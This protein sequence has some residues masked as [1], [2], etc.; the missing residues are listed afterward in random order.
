MFFVAERCDSGGSNSDSNKKDEANG[1]I[2]G[3][4]LG[5]IFGILLIAGGIATWMYLK[6]RK[7]E[8]R[9]YLINEPEGPSRED[10]VVPLRSKELLSISEQDEDAGE[11]SLSPITVYSVSRSEAPSATG[12]RDPEQRTTNSA[13]PPWMELLTASA[14]TGSAPP[15]TG[16]NTENSFIN[17]FRMPNALTGRRY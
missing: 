5:V 3:F 17:S 12:L 15:S 1:T 8:V 16:Y 14:R 7:G 2:V 13:T 6:K 9:D 11:L 4:V 10:T